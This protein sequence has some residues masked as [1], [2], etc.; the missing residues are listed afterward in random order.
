MT[1]C[2]M[3]A[4]LQCKAEVYCNRVGCLVSR[5]SLLGVAI[6]LRGV[7]IEHNRHSSRCV[8]YAC[9][10]T[11]L[12]FGTLHCAVELFEPQCSCTVHKHCSCALFKKKKSTK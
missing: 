10:K 3:T 11:M 7:G 1:F 2:V 6:G 8:S 12:P 9:D 5:H 4:T